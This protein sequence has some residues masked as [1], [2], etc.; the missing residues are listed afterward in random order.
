MNL[1][2]IFSGRKFV[3]HLIADDKIPPV[4]AVKFDYLLA[5]NGLFVRAKRTEF[6]VCLPIFHGKIEGL[7]NIK[8]EIVWHGE[9]IPSRIWREILENARGNG[10]FARFKEDVYVVYRHAETSGWHTKNIGKERS[11]ASTI[12]DDSLSEYGAACLEIHTHPPNAIHFSQL[13]DRDEQGKF[14]IFGI[15]VD[16]Y[17]QNPKIRF[18]CGIYDYFGQ[19]PAS[20]VGEMPSALIDLNSVEQGSEKEWK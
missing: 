19:I 16:I 17:S 7:P 18:R 8:S 6:S 1:T 20:F 5:G 12:A 11:Y 15:L 9:Q 13:D 2:D 10:D 4:N 14:R 3:E